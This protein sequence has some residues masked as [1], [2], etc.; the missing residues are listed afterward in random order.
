MSRCWLRNSADKYDMRLPLPV[1][2]IESAIPSGVAEMVIDAQHF[3]RIVRDGILKAQTSLDIST[4][5]FKAM[6]IPD[7][8]GGRRARFGARAGRRRKCVR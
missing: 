7:I 3:H 1:A 8:G 6:L 5:D 2:R 4:A